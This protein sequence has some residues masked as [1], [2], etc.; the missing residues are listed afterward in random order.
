MINKYYKYLIITALLSSLQSCT[1]KTDEMVLIPK[2]IFLMGSTEEDKEYLATEFGDPNQEYYI[3]EQPAWKLELEEYYIDKYEVTNV[4]YYN[5]TKSTKHRI[6][7]HWL[8]GKYDEDKY[9]NPVINVTWYDAFAYCQ[10]KGLRLPTEPEWEKAAK[11]PS[12][13][14]YTWG[15]DFDIT[16][17]NLGTGSTTEV[18][19][20]KTDISEYGV[21][22][23]GGN[24]MEWVDGW[25]IPYPDYNGPDKI[26]KAQHQVVRGGTAGVKGHYALPQIYSRTTQRHHIEPYQYGGDTGF[27]CAKGG[28]NTNGFN[29]GTGLADEK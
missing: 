6:P 3:N 9:F 17:A 28:K 18:G 29:T 8:N 14:R 13:N 2:G 5:F 20:I 15:H 23:M 1:K 4:D 21:F 10:W 19:T 27:R 22:D 25:H 16:K 7:P 26:F 11:G 24:V 12:G